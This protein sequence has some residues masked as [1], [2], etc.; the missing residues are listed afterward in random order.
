[1]RHLN[2]V[3]GIAAAISGLTT[4]DA[5]GAEIQVLQITNGEQ[6]VQISGQ[7]A[8]E[9]S[10]K[11]RKA[12]LSATSA[13]VSLASPGGSVNAAIQIGDIIRDLGMTT[14]VGRGQYCASACG[15]IWLAGKRRLLTPTSRLGFHTAYVI[16]S[17]QRVGS[18]DGNALIARYIARLDLPQQS[19]AFATAAGPDDLTWLDRST[20]KQSGIE[21]E[22]IDAER[23]R[24]LRPNADE[25]FWALVT[26]AGRSPS[27]ATA[28]AAIASETLASAR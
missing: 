15:L 2:I 25:A 17:G 18:A 9:D 13:S 20:R 10:Q 1:M 21:L 23:S 8:L 6:I 3:L 5:V 7:I 16:R 22:I 24:N 28:P 27:T 4:S 14:V 26:E 19:F 12:A 11:F